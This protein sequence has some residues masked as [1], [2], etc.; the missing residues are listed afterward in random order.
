MTGVGSQQRAMAEKVS[1]IPVIKDTYL[2]KIG[3]WCRPPQEE[4]SWGGESWVKVIAHRQV[5]LFLQLGTSSTCSPP[6]WNPRLSGGPRLSPM[7][8]SLDWKEKS[9]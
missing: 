1:K 2:Q 9:C 8:P 7:T 3:P 6:S 4:T 5:F